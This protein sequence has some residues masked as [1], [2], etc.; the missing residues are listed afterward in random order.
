MV[1]SP[2]KDTTGMIDWDN[3]IAEN[4]ISLGLEGGIDWAVLGSSKLCA[5]VMPD[6]AEHGAGAWRGYRRRSNTESGGECC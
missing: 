6:I 4:M 1:S 3:V 2:H 5:L